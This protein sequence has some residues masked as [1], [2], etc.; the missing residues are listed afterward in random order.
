MAITFLRRNRQLAAKIITTASLNDVS[1]AET[2]DGGNRTLIN[3]GTTSNLTRD[4]D[5]ANASEVNSN[6]STTQEI[7]VTIT[8]V[9]STQYSTIQGTTR[10]IVYNIDDFVG[11][12][13]S[14]ETNGTTEGMATGRTVLDDGPPTQT[15]QSQSITES[16]TTS[17]DFSSLTVKEDV[18]VASTVTRELTVDTTLAATITQT[19]AAGTTGV[20]IDP[21][22]TESTM[23]ATARQLTSTTILDFFQDVGF[24]EG[25]LFPVACQLAFNTVFQAG[26]C[27]AW[28]IYRGAGSPSPASNH[29]FLFFTDEA[30]IVETT[31][32]ITDG[33]TTIR[34]TIESVQTTT[35]GAKMQLSQGGIAGQAT[36][37]VGVYQA[38]TNSGPLAPAGST[39]QI[40]VAAS[41]TDTDE[42]TLRGQG[43]LNVRALGNV[44]L[45]D[46]LNRNDTLAIEGEVTQS[47][48]QVQGRGFA[49]IGSPDYT[50]GRGVYDL[51]YVN[52][53]SSSSSRVSIDAESIFTAANGEAYTAKPILAFVSITG[54]F[55]NNLEFAVRDCCATTN[56]P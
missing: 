20:S 41:V 54:T 11:F 25:D 46:T 32:E 52:G 24:T 33:N 26:E 30:S 39:Y 43:T 31:G 34:S 13:Q 50:F 38:A 2:N 14:I 29:T 53:S 28:Q 23:T 19:M 47:T 3:N 12:L 17:Q 4:Y 48:E 49:D 1:S 55:T 10:N 27:E 9:S 40:Q 6:G 18:A 56:L 44:S 7:Q 5:C 35:Y 51:T 15:T 36:I 16:F 8:G 22:T 42:I 21:T 45:I 37:I